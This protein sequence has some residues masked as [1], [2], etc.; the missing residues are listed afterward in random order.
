[1]SFLYKSHVCNLCSIFRRTLSNISGVMR[2]DVSNAI[3]E[4]LS[5]LEPIYDT[6]LQQV[7]TVFL[8]ILLLFPM[9]PVL[10]LKYDLV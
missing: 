6:R 4:A 10:F 1:M 5:C 8:F 2:K 7:V 9:S 3:G